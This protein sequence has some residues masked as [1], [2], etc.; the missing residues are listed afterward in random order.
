MH[1]EPR[2]TEIQDFDKWPAA[3]RRL[4]RHD[5]QVAGLN[6]PVR[7]TEERSGCD[8]SHY[9]QPDTQDRVG[10]HR[11]MSN[12]PG[13]NRFAFQVFRN[14]AEIIVLDPNR[15]DF[16]DVDMIEFLRR[17]R[18]FFELLAFRSIDNRK[19]DQ[20]QHDRFLRASVDGFVIRRRTRAADFVRRA[21]FIRADS[22]MFE[23]SCLLHKVTIRQA[24]SP[25]RMPAGIYWNKQPLRARSCARNAWLPR[26]DSNQE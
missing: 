10:R 15:Q 17:P 3:I 13:I 25:L 21:V 8:R 16:R 19:R 18:A 11:P 4:A 24:S 7:Q 20:L 2:Q 26:L 12:D 6:G 14:Q 23:K 22:V 1:F 9:L 5:H